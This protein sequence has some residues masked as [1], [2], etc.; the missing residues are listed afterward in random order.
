M[1]LNLK[2]S[3]VCRLSLATTSIWVDMNRE[4]NDPETTEN[5][6]KVLE[7]SMKMWRDLHDK[8]NAQLDEWDAK[9]E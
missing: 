2:R 9:H 1:T 5:R 4:Y 8:I 7:G 3:E 6:K